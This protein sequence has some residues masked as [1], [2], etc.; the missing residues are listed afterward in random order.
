MGSKEGFPID[1][2]GWH[3]E[4]RRNPETPDRVRKRFR[5]L[6]DFLHSNHLTVRQLL[7]AEEEPA[8]EFTIHSTDLTEEGLKV[9]TK[10]YD[11]WLKR[12]VNKN[13]DVADVSILLKALEEIRAA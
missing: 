8:N 9:M 10:G 1:K 2:V 4:V 6:V 11:K 12:V 13:K 5:I 3:T 7:P